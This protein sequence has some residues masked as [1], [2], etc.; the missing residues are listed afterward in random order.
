MAEFATDYLVI[1]A[2]AVGLAFADTLL[3]ETE[4]ATI[5]IVDRH[6][7]PGGHWN[8][9]Y[10]FVALHQPS[11]FYGVNSLPLGSGEK[12]RFGVNE[13]LYELASG[14]EVLGYF[15][16]VMRRTLLPSGRVRYLPMTEHLGDGLCRSLLSGDEVRIAVRRKV[17]DATYYGTSVPATHRPKYEIA[18]GTR[19]ITPNALPHLGRSQDPVPGRY[20]ILGAGKTAMDVGVWLI[21]SGLDPDRISWIVPRDSWLINRRTTQPGPEFFDD[22]IG[23]QAR[24]FAVYAQAPSADAMFE[25]LEEAGVMLRIDRSVTPS[26]FHFA[27]ISELEVETLRRIRDIVRLGRV[28]AI[29]PDG[30]VLEGGR[31]AMAADALYIDCTASAVERRPAVSIFQPGLIVPQLVRAPQPAFSAAL[32][33]YVEARYPDDDAKNALCGTVPF[34]DRPE[35]YPAT[36]LANFRN[37]AA[38]ARD[39]ALRAWIRSSR[40]DGFGKVVDAVSPEE[41]DKLAVLAQLRKNALPAAANLARLSG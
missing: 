20:V 35:D 26:M 12:D 7:L 17:V 19:L 32:A 39:P 31:R 24:A 37:E 27:T 23:A 21:G 14:P 18:G 36:L 28:K 15:G 1:G 9:A 6:G 33:G 22:A 10:P 2:G 38:W 3:A 25:A 41:A 8:D 30:L 13:G 29:E 16:A 4:E 40:L 34:P 5:T 11:A